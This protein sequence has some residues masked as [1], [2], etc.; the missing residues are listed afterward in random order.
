MLLGSQTINCA[1]V[2]QQDSIWILEQPAGG[3]CFVGACAHVVVP[4]AA[5]FPAYVSIWPAAL[6][7]LDSHW[8]Q[9]R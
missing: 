4:R 3:D 7:C 5:T 2:P 9:A 6:P 1:N 8:P